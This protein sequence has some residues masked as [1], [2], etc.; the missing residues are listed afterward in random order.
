M[1]RRILGVLLVVLFL[2]NPAI[3]RTKKKLS[4]REFAQR[5]YALLY[6]LKII[7]L[8]N[9]EEFKTIAPFLSPSL[10]KLLFAA[11]QKQSEYMRK[12]P[13]N[14]PPW[15]EGDLFSNSMEEILRYKVGTP[16]IENS[17]VRIPVRV[18]SHEEKFMSRW[19][20]TLLLRRNNSKWVVTNVIYETQKKS[21]S[22]DNLRK[23]LKAEY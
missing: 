4:P 10:Q 16:E 5:F 15:I 22:Y 8:P 17:L 20:D 2:G 14:K 13:T 18:T 3:A 21:K 7:G 11:K 23:I 1:I 6:E 9:A 12:N 19:T